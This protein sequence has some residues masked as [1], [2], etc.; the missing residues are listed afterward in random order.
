MRISLFH[1]SRR[2]HFSLTQS[3]INFGTMSPKLIAKIMRIAIEPSTSVA[4]MSSPVVMATTMS[5]AQISR[6]APRFIRPLI[7]SKCH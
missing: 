2:R 5:T 6:A 1:Y 7:K 3:M 4:P